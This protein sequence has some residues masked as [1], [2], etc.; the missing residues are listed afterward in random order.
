MNP[1]PIQEATQKLPELFAAA[2]RGEEVTITKDNS[3]IKLIPAQ[4]KKPRQ[5]GSAKGQVWM[6]DDFDEPLE[7]FAEYM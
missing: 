4:I 1:I 2:L 3:G 5:P 6:S 7:E